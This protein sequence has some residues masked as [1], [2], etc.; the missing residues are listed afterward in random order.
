MN[1]LDQLK[2]ILE[3]FHSN[4]CYP[5]AMPSEVDAAASEIMKLLQPGEAPVE[6]LPEGI[7]QAVFLSIVDCHS[8]YPDDVKRAFSPL[9]LQ[10]VHSQTRQYENQ[11]IHIEKVLK[12]A[13]DIVIKNEN[14][15]EEQQE[16]LAAAKV[17]A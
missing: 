8:H 13:I 5:S 12:H 14:D 10:Y 15:F 7:R 2:A 6:K 9:E 17:S 16:R 4:S 11:E 1:Q 3:H